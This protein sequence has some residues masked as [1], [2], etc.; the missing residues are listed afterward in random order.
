[1]LIVPLQS[2]KRRRAALLQK[3]QHLL[4]AVPLMTAGVQALRRGAHGFELALALFE[5][6]TSALLFGSVVREIRAARRPRDA[7]AH[8]GAH[9]VDWF[10]IFAAGVLLA[11]A[12]ERWHQTHHWPRPMLL[13][14]LTSL[15]L[16]LM[17]GRIDAGIQRRRALRMD[18]EGIFFSTRPWSR[19]RAKWKDIT[20]IEIG[21]RYATITTR[22]GRN[23]RLDLADLDSAERIRAALAEAAA[24]IRDRMPT[25]E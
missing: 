10:H 13:T 11:E 24:R 16:G 15:V 8:H 12:A 2:K 7:H 19:F 17:H 9:S 23:G 21:T 6:A 5:I 4:P 18:D 22:D 20:G 1:V 3:Y 14:A 25:A